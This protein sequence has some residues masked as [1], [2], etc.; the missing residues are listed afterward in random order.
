MVIMPDCQL[1]Q[2]KHL[3]KESRDSD[4]AD[5]IGVAPASQPDR[6]DEDPSPIRVLVADDH[7]ILRKGLVDLLSEQPEIE[8]VGAA[9][10]G[11]AAVDL[12]L[13]TQPD[14]VI[15]DVTMPRLNGIEAT[16]KIVERLPEVRVIGLSMHERQDMATAMREAGAVA[17]FMK[18]GAAEEMISAIL[19]SP[20]ASRRP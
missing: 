13:Q 7:E 8:V 5:A 4:S 15:M 12:A 16:R 14:V 2:H 18:S 11:Q 6:A 3:E 10:D 9:G 1:M 19:D 20:K 17:Y